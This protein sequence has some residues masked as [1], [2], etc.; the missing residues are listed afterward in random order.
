MA[1]HK[2]LQLQLLQVCV[3]RKRRRKETGFGLVDQCTD[4][5][6]IMALLSVRSRSLGVWQLVVGGGQLVRLIRGGSL[7]AFFAGS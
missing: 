1:H 6:K 5:L 3:S 4:G 2:V 7:C